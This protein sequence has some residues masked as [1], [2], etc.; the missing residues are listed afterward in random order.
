MRRLLW[1]TTDASYQVG[2][3]SPV[4]L[5]KR[6][7]HRILARVGEEG[8]LSAHL[9]HCEAL[10]HKVLEMEFVPL[11]VVRDPRAVLA[12][13]VPFVL[14]YEHHALHRA[15][16]S[17][18]KEECYWAAFRGGEFGSTTLKSMLAR[19]E[20]LASWYGHDDVV[21]IRFEDIVGARG[22]GSDM[23]QLQTLRRLCRVLDFP[24]ERIDTVLAQL[25][26]PG[27]GTFRKGQIDSWKNELPVNLISEAEK[28]LAPILHRWG[29]L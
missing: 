6:A 11:V 21:K 1:K 18:G 20:S 27:R 26:G 7:V 28:E 2:I 22:G 29:Y 9:G 12:S 15:F 4:E 14:S 5:P 16:L 8:F 25:F 13:F 3:D 17:L 10:L 23:L 24:A 19:C